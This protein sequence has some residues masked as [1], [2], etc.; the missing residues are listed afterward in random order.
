MWTMRLIL[1]LMPFCCALQAGDDMDLQHLETLGHMAKAQDPAIRP[2]HC[3]IDSNQ[4]MAS[5]GCYRMT[6]GW[7]SS[8]CFQEE[9]YG[10]YVLPPAEVSLD[11][12]PATDNPASDLSPLLSAKRPRESLHPLAHLKHLASLPI[13]SITINDWERG[14]RHPAPP[15]PE[16]TLCTFLEHVNIKGVEPPT[17]NYITDKTARF[18][19]LVDQFSHVIGHYQKPRDMLASDFD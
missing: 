14:Y 7:A 4:D 13:V 18:Q 8:S 17:L 10:V 16:E 6:L 11:P 5:K 3:T 19:H 12:T 9:A 15:Q 2:M 1:C